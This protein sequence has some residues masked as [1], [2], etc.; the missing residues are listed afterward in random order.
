MS[1][2][3]PQKK[4][5]E[6]QINK[7]HGHNILLCHILPQPLLQPPKEEILAGMKDIAQIRN[8]QR[9]KI[10]LLIKNTKNNQTK[11]KASWRN[12]HLHW[13]SE[14]RVRFWQVT[15]RRQR[16]QRHRGRTTRDQHMAQFNES[17]AHGDRSR[18]PVSTGPWRNP[19]D[20]ALR[21]TDF[22]QQATVSH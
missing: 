21:N 16:Q 22:T 18:H 10:I 5:S 11:K 12:Q 13:T 15:A 20:G 1:L 9:G 4:K 8:K 19:N 7:S 2:L 17:T 6:I 3:A 14:E